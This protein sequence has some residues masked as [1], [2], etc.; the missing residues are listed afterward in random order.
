MRFRALILM[1]VMC[2]LFQLPALA[3]GEEHS[4]GH[5]TFY[6]T[7]AIDGINIFYREAGPPGAP[8]ILLLHGLPSSAR[9]F[10][11]LFAR[12][13]D[14]F[15]LVAPDYPGFGHSDW[16][17]PKKFAYTFD[18]IAEITNH[19]A[20]K[21]GLTRYTLYVQDYGGPM[22]FRMALAHPERVEALIVQDA[23]AH[24]EGLGA[25]WKA[26]REFW[27]NRAAN[28]ATLRTNL[29]SLA[30]TKTRHIGNDPDVE[31]Y[32]PDLWT[33][34]FAFLSAPGQAEIQSDLFYDYRT[35]VEAYPKW[36]AWMREKQPRLLVIWGKYEL[37]FD[38]SEPEA[39]RR[40][41]PKAE[42]HIVDGGH[43]AL[44]TAADEIAGL[45]RGFVGKAT[46]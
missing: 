40:D 11:P 43:F 44:D 20:E 2:A 30:T 6:R 26:R 5:P 32:D 42:V 36:Q 27:A 16:P 9:M 21:L 41:V 29:L 22:G 1:G 4:V 14:R 38:P 17:D 3:Q 34:E 23:V 10:E 45:V 31:R 8:V 39:Y 25:N 7:I 15:H 24:N 33:D 46:K 19:F 12:L 28:E 18:H 35:N 13:A 37:S